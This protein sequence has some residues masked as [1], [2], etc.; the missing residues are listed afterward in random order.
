MEIGYEKGSATAIALADGSASIYL[1][2]GGGSIGGAGH[3]SIR[4]AAQRMVSVAAKFQ[5]QTKTTKDFPLPKN[6]QTIF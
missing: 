6:G 5:P 4:K 3:E 2:T 1:S